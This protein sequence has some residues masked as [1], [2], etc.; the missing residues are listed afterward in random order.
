M[1]LDKFYKTFSDLDK[2]YE[3]MK[4]SLGCSNKTD[5]LK[6]IC[7]DK[8]GNNL[9]FGQVKSLLQK[10]YESYSEEQKIQYSELIDC[11][12]SL[13]LF[14]MGN[15]LD[16]LDPNVSLNML[17]TKAVLMK[18]Q[19]TTEKIISEEEL[20][21]RTV[22]MDLSKSISLEECFEKYGEISDFAKVTKGK[23]VFV[24]IR[25]EALDEC[26]VVTQDVIEQLKARVES[27][28][29]GYER[30]EN[31]LFPAIVQVF[32]LKSSDKTF[33]AYLD[34]K[35]ICMFPKNRYESGKL[36]GR[37][38]TKVAETDKVVLVDYKG[39]GLVLY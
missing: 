8:S 29:F 38:V 3:N 37:K 7:Y 20:L 36:L 30:V 27:K 5:F 19:S 32:D 28:S 35:M 21:G 10:E 18:I 6:K 25:Y 23:E 34:R 24:K 11:I 1:V 33:K 39:I 17:V 2:S 16:D 13:E 9:I 26:F 4:N 31:V 14:L 15:D 22:P 12:S